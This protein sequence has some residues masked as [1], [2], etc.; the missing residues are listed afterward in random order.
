MYSVTSESPLANLA[1][2]MDHHRPSGRAE[3]DDLSE[4]LRDSRPHGPR[5]QPV[6][7][8]FKRIEKQSSATSLSLT[9]QDG[10]KIS[11]ELR[12]KEVSKSAGRVGP[13]TI[14]LKSS[15]RFSEKF[16]VRFEGHIDEDERAAIKGIMESAFDAAE[17][18]FGG[19]D[20]V[21][22][23]ALLAAGA[24]ASDEI[25]SFSLRLRQESSLVEKYRLGDSGPKIVE[26]MESSEAFRYK[27]EAFAE[28]NKRLVERASEQLD[29][30]GAVSLV[31]ATLAK[32]L[33]AVHTERLQAAAERPVGPQAPVDGPRR[34]APGNTVAPAAR[35]PVAT[36]AP[37]P[38]IAPAV[39]TEQSGPVAKPDAAVAKPD[40][41][42]DATRAERSDEPSRER[43]I[44]A[45]KRDESERVRMPPE[46]LNASREL[47][48][49]VGN[50]QKTASYAVI[51]D[52]A[53]QSRT[54]L[55]VERLS[56]LA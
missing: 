3:R 53:Q 44:E 6:E 48:V 23:D 41:K 17:T 20:D 22:V 55:V 49:K 15:E 51:L 12:T 56:L 10:D 50:P 29:A 30:P 34:E 35:E 39:P 18:F 13:G 11:I 21:D 19:S 31:Q 52:I 45:P 24:D 33:D 42:P 43:P 54:D 16:D 5:P 38:K 27:F 7:G 4:K 37:E 1:K 47:S 25:A 9:T 36:V 26:R 14:V 28:S 40:E 2:V 8:F 32:S 46:Q